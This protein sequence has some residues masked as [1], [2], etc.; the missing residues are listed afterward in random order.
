MKSK[1]TKI[2]AGVVLASVGSVATAE[3]FYIDVAA[4]GSTGTSGAPVITDDD[5][6]T[7]LA[8]QWQ[9]FADTTT[10]QYDT[11]SD[12]VL[13]VGDEF[14]DSGDAVFTALLQSNL[15]PSPSEL[16]S[17]TEGLTGFGVAG[18]A[19]TAHWTNLTGEI[20]SININGVTDATIVQTYSG[21]TIDFYF[22]DFGDVAYDFGGGAGIAGTGLDGLYVGTAD[23]SGFTAG[24]QVLS[25]SL[26]SGTGSSTFNPTVTEYITGSFDINFD[27]T[28]ALDGFWNFF[29]GT[30]FAELLATNLLIRSNI[31]A[32][33]DNVVQRA[34]TNGVLF[35]VDSDHDG[36][37]T[38]ERP[39][40]VPG[41]IA[42]VGL[43]L[44][45]LGG[46][47]RR[48]KVAA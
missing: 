8:D 48:R 25:L 1:L 30:D 22:Q 13:T 21:G 36:S 2:A 18:S 12:G 35:E 20:E 7:G 6:N 39:V 16:A 24:Q 28:F 42:L 44:L 38:F 9:L 43:G 32:N 23:N 47:T 41:T 15:T 26:V 33:T 19:I 14:E 37:I 5:T 27:V 17:D 34:G 46:L 4:A 40:P 45:G 11:I 31:D 29:G 3:V 10:V